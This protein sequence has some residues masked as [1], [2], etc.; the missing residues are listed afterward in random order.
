MTEAWGV[1]IAALVAGVVAVAGS[2]I[3]LYVGRR[4]VQD[5]ASAEHEQWLRNQQKEAY[6]KY[7]AAWDKAFADVRREALVQRPP[8]ADVINTS[9]VNSFDEDDWHR[10]SGTVK[11]AFAAVEPEREQVL[12]LGPASV[13]LAVTRMG[14]VLEVLRLAF[15]HELLAGPRPDVP[16]K[17]ALVEAQTARHNLADAMR[18]QVRS[19]PMVGPVKQ[20]GGGQQSRALSG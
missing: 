20:R 2:F 17:Q 14:E 5:Q 6:S 7:L 15:I 1:V 18:M 10:A 9:R 8:E 13:D 11:A 12:L 4:Q 16:W 3:G 19:A